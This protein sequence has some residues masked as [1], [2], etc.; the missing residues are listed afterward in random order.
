MAWLTPFTSLTWWGFLVAGVCWWWGCCCVPPTPRNKRNSHIPRGRLTMTHQLRRLLRERRAMCGSCFRRRGWDQAYKL[1]I[2][3]MY[4][5]PISC[6]LF[7]WWNRCVSKAKKKAQG[8][9]LARQVYLFRL[10]TSSKIYKSDNLPALWNKIIENILPPTGHLF[11]CIDPTSR[12]TKQNYFL[13]FAFHN[14]SEA[15]TLY[16]FLYCI[17]LVALQIKTL[18]SKA[19][20]KLI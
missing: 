4:H 18:P 6:D 14:S 3:S 9:F 15:N 19:D 13:I 11:S 7:C 5:Y 8:C 16:C 10:L 12:K 20:Y 1:V 2:D 17:Y